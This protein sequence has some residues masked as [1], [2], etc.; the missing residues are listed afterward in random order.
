[1]IQAIIFDC[2]GVLATDGW[3]PFK[4]QHF[5]H[6][7]QLDREATDFNKQANAGLI[8]ADDFIA[9][10]ARL[11]AVPAED[12]RRAVTRSAAN[13]E[14]LA[15]IAAHLKPKYQVGLLS[16]AGTDMLASIFS[17][18]QIALF[19]QIDLSYQTGLVKPDTRAYDK[20]ARNLQVRPEE[21]LFVD[22][23]ERHCSG[24]AEAGMQ[25]LVYTDF[26]AF[27]RQ[28]EDLLG[29]SEE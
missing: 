24:A 23:Q 2:F 16:N 1:M 11:A 22:D 5:A 18:D 13:E 9:A 6:S 12:V 17:P 26:E 4:R 27:R 3:I 15:Y 25:A 21:C 7:K 19:D 8:S 29:N 20:I 28:L 10:I 14:L